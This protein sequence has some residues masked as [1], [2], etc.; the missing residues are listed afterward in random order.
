M[1]DYIQSRAQVSVLKETAKTAFNAYNQARQDTD[2]KALGLTDLPVLK[3]DPAKNQGE[4]SAQLTA[5][6]KALSTSSGPHA[7]PLEVARQSW[8]SSETSVSKALLSNASLIVPAPGA[9]L[10]GWL[11]ESGAPF[12]LGILLIAAGAFMTR[13]AQHLP[14]NAVQFR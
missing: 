4:R 11:G 8:L 14:C 7:G 9:R 13:K 5:H 6:L 2:L 1:F 3:I 10:L 12:C